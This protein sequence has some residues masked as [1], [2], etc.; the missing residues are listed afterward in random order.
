MVR[1]SAC[2]GNASNRLT[3]LN[4]DGPLMPP[5]PSAGFNG[6]ITSLAIQ[7]DGKI[8]V[9]GTFTQFNGAAHGRIVRA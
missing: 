4:P 8:L 6:N 3:R 1:S 2:N 5:S 7:A 9:M